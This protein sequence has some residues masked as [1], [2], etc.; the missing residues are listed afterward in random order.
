[1]TKTTYIIT[2]PCYIIEDSVWDNICSQCTSEDFYNG[3]FNK[4]VADH[5]TKITGQQAYASET[6]FGDWSNQLFASI[7]ELL[8]NTGN[9]CADSGMV[10][11]A[12]YDAALLTKY[13]PSTISNISAIFEVEGE[14]KVNID[15]SNNDWTQ[16]T[17]SDSAG[18]T[19]STLPAD[20]M[21]EEDYDEDDESGY[22]DDHANW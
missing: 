7:P 10:C 21:F 18:H 17:M 12:K 1:M 3:K 6:G 16:I 5:L 22:F 13:A 20:V 15:T 4:L 14:L 8:K 11:V 19:F 2:D 9:F